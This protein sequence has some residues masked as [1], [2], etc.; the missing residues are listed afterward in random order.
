[1]TTAPDPT[2]LEYRPAAPPRPPVWSR[3]LVALV[4]SAAAVGLGVVA[5]A[6]V[7]RVGSAAA[8]RYWPF[9]VLVVSVGVIVALIT[10][11]RLHA[12]LA[13]I[14]AAM[15]AGLMARAGSLP[16][17]PNL[18]AGAEQPGHWVRAVELTTAAVGKTAGDVGLAIALASVIGACL[19]ESGAADKIVR[20]S[21]A[22]FGPRR[23]G[24]ALLVGAYV[25]S[26]PLFFNTL[27]MLLVPIARALRMR[28]GKD[29]VLYLMAICGAGVLTHSLTVPHPGPMA[30]VADFHLDPGLT[31]SLG[32]LTG[33]VPLAVGWA[34]THWLDRRVDVPLSQT[35]A[36]G[37]ENPPGREPAAVA[38]QPEENLPSLPASL[39]PVVL[40]VV[41]LSLASLAGGFERTILNRYS[42]TA[43]AIALDA[44]QFAGNANVALMI[45]TAV[46][47]ALLMRRRG[48]TLAGVGAVIAP[49]LETAAVMILIIAAGGAFGAML[50]NAGVGDAIKAAAAGVD[51]SL[52]L[53]SWAV[54]LVLRIAQGSATVAMLTTS[55]MIAPM[56]AAARTAAELPYHPVYL[57]L[58][59]G[60]GAFG[61]SWMNDSGFWL[62]SRLGG[63]TERQTLKTWTVLL[64]V[65]SVVGLG[66]TLVLAKVLPLR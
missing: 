51:V 62:V 33:L 60:Y 17:V 26:I 31:L 40:P 8:V 32:L 16:R 1:M 43:V 29:Y 47:V 30:M 44:A 9:V 13:L 45:G 39:A 35:E 14:L 38:L 2:T 12:F 58:S 23:A 7:S 59:I 42:S 61:V 55:A 56:A 34:V 65:N 18:A 54:A 4:A 49:P 3:S 37:P 66:T 20:R 11:A 25:V 10:V 52:I 41:L 57:F 19:L 5:S 21:L 36:G 50:R 27:F 6:V 46:A 15:S 64:T 28:T 53:L 63:M 22:L 24:L 48:L